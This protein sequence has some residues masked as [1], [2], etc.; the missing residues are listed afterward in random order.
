MPST[1]G[2]AGSPSRKASTCSA[3]WA[4]TAVAS[5]VSQAAVRCREPPVSWAAMLGQ[6]GSRSLRCRSWQ[7]WQDDRPGSTSGPTTPVVSRTRATRCGTPARSSRSDSTG[8]LPAP[9]ASTARSGCWRPRGSSGPDRRRD[10]AGG[11]H[12]GVLAA[13][14]DVL[15]RGGGRCD[16]GVLGDAGVLD[17]DRAHTRR[18]EQ[19]GD[20]GTHP[21]G[22]GDLDHRPPAPARGPRRRP[23]CR[24]AARPRQGRGR[25]GPARPGSDRPATGGRPRRPRAHR[26]GSAPRAARRA[27]RRRRRAGRRRPRARAGRGSRRGC[28]APAPPRVQAA[29]DHGVRGIDAECSVLPSRQTRRSA[30]LS[31]GR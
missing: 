15:R 30:A 22:A 5:T 21:A 14:A 4:A 20:R 3:A 10:P 23:R 31:R 7:R 26:P 2:G 24:R 1:A 8:S 11:S 12:R 6:A 13:G 28:R 25:A 19:R 16:V 27:G 18:R 29:D 17:D 9:A